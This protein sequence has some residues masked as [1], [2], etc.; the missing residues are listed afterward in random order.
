MR[1]LVVP[2]I[3]AEREVEDTAVL[4]RRVEFVVAQAVL[5]LHELEFAGI[6]EG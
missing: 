6:V 4:E 3:H 5:N 1:E 2:G